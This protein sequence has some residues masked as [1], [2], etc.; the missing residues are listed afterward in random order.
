[1]CYSITGGRRALKSGLTVAV[2]MQERGFD[3][4]TNH[5]TQH[6]PL[7]GNVLDA[8]DYLWDYA[9]VL[10]LANRL[11]VVLGSDFGRTP[12]YNVGSGKDHWPIGSYVVMEK[13]AG[14]TNRV[15]G[16][17]DEGHNAYAIDPATLKRAS[18]G[19]LLY[20]KH[21]HQA[22]RRYLGSESSAVARLFPYDN[23][24]S[25]ALFG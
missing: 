24:E 23:T 7:L 1:L 3:T 2:D 4:H 21:V 25:M 18:Q 5:D 9:E 10:G 14:Y 13:N 17:T 11:V 19:S 12:Y 20:A 8:V 6:E 16:E 22:L 15:V